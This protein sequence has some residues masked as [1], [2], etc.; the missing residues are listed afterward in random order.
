MVY[1]DYAIKILT[2]VLTSFY[3]IAGFAIIMAILFMFV[4]MSYVDCGWKTTI[5]KWLESFK[6]NRMFRR[7]FLLAFYTA[8]I[9]F[10]T[11]F[12]RDLWFR[13]LE[14]IIGIWGL[15]DANGQFTTEVI[16]N[17]MLFIPFAFLFILVFKDKIVKDGDQ[18]RFKHLIFRTVSCTFLFSLTIELLQML[19]RIGTFQLSDIFYNTLGSLI[20]GFI[21]WVVWK[22][23]RR[24]IKDC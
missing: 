18:V 6:K 11:L 3:Q 24:K 16:E 20:G 8:M 21:Y 13:P 17:L 19:L 12:N 10:R 15:Y 5:Q 22:I 2:S 1:I 9:L 4:Y 23:K 14:H 7:V